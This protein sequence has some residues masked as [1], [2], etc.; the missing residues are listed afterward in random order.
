MNSSLSSRNAGAA[1]VAIVVALVGCTHPPAGPEPSRSVRVMEIG[2]ASSSESLRLAGE[3]R[4]RHEARVGFRVGGKILRRYVDV[5][6]HIK[7]GAR[8]V[9]LDAADYVL[10][11]DAINGQL[12]AAQA[13][14]AFAADELQRYQ[15][16]RDQELISA[17]DLDR[18]QTVTA[19]LRERV[20]T[21]KAQLEQA[22]NQVGY[23]RL[24]TD[25]DAIVTTVLAEAGQVVSAGQA[26]AVLARPEELEVAIDVPEDRRELLATA[27]AVEISFWARPDVRVAGR[28]RELSASANPASRTYAARISLR[29]RPAWVQLG[30]S[31][32]AHIAGAASGERAIPLSAVFQPHSEAGGEARVWLV[33]REG[34]AVSSMPIRLGA[35]IGESEIVAYGLSPGQRIVTAG[36][37]RLREGAPVKVLSAAGLGAS[38]TQRTVS[39]STSLARTPIASQA[40]GR[41]NPQ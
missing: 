17:A 7:A 4:A 25:Y 8:I 26:V 28:V 6:D 10:A 24:G 19:T 35:P 38:P 16:L 13:E 33:N 2:A 1:V 40:G 36:T 3:V 20:A 9:E 29:E 5:G 41:P 31:A 12:N 22:K 14:L 23:A 11:V 15:Q 27:S 39:D 18:R 32:T 21:L 34:T 30:M 37:S